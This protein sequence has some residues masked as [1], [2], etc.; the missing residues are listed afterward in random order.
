MNID[1][2][3]N[4]VT[5]FLRI[6]NENNQGKVSDLFSFFCKGILFIFQK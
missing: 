1:P 5:V 6:K 4:Y 3:R 2:N